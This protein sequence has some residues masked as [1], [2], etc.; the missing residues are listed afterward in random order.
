MGMGWMCIGDFNEVLSSGGKSGGRQRPFNQVEAFRATTESCSFFDMGYVGNKF[1]WTNGRS[2][3]AF[4]KERI[5]RALCN[6][7]W[8][9]LFPFSKVYN[10]P[11]LSSDHCPILVSMEQ[12]ELD[13]TRKARPF[14]YEASWALKEDFNEVLEKAWSK[15]RRVDG[16]L[17]QV[18]EGLNQCRVELVRWHKQYAGNYRVELRK[19]WD[20]VTELQR[21]NEGHLTE[22]IK[23][24]QNCLELV[25]A[26]V[27]EEQNGML[28]RPY[29]QQEVKTALF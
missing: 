27:T 10:L 12:F 26:T 13:S 21:D 20:Q 14:K 15:P 23:Q 2:G 17:C 16:K 28:M 18:I 9:E 22:K 6:V 3:Q 4:I 1:T 19:L 24:V 29:T 25:E 11:T 8:S 7:E 5:D